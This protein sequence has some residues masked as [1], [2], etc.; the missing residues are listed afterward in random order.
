M[1]DI[2]SNQKSELSW[3]IRLNKHLSFNNLIENLSFNIDDYIPGDETLLI[4]ASRCGR[5]EMVKRI[6]ELGANID[7]SCQKSNET[8]LMKAVLYNNID[9]VIYLISNGADIN[10]M[11]NYNQNA[12]IYAIRAES[13]LLTTLLID[14]GINYINNSLKEARKRGINDII[15]FLANVEILDNNLNNVYSQD[16]V[17]SICLN[18]FTDL[19]CVILDCNH[20]YHD[21]CLSQWIIIRR[22]C[23]KCRRSF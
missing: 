19:S 14:N 23:P 12:L 9:V 6:V 5:T 7:K 4:L 22:N 3:S 15:N 18:D 20:M 11:N 16:D 17:C 13:L 21:S 1:S 8:A 10:K 2:I